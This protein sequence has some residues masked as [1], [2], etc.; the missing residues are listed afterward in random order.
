MKFPHWMHLESLV[1]GFL[2]I[3]LFSCN[4]EPK[5]I[6]ENKELPE[7]AIEAHSAPDT[8][9]IPDNPEGVMIR[10]G[11]ELIFNTAK[12]I[13]PN[14]SA[15]KYLG[16]KMNCTN[17]HLDGG[18]RPFGFNFFST[19]SIYPQYRSREN[20]VLTI[21]QRVNNC[22]ERPHNGIPLPLDSKE[23]VAFVSYIKW[24]GTDVPIGSKVSGSGGITLEYPERAAD[25][26]KG[27]AIYQRECVTCHLE[28]GSGTWTSDS[29][30][31]TYP[32]LWGENS[33]QPGSS[34]FRIIKAAQFIKANMPFGTAFWDKPKL[35]D[36]EA[37]DVAAY[38]NSSEHFRPS[39]GGADY[40]DIRTKYVDYPFGPYDDP[41]SEAQH[42]L[43]PFQPIIDYRKANKLYLK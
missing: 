9:S 41:F 40:K 17:C 2:S 39:K 29:S 23:M 12:L 11:R 3:S 30:T 20:A 25:P 33:Y 34:M 24:L 35:S 13:G 16:N 5:E 27:K 1:Y 6:T 21:E 38:I 37:L 15:G 18:T 22:I 26:V 10:Y 19:Y 31:F 36:E 14:G 7:K 4:T 8:S 43:G 28:D 42:K 32:P